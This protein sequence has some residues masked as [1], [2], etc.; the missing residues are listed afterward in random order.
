MICYR[1]GQITLGRKV[2]QEFARDIAMRNVKE[3]A[4]YGM[5]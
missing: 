5:K 4:V 2:L 3:N 1:R